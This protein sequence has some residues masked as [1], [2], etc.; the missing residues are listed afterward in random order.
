MVVLIGY[1][2]KNFEKVILCDMLL[3]NSDIIYRLR[4]FCPRVKGKVRLE[5]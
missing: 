5:G 4:K 1:E 3:S 2:W